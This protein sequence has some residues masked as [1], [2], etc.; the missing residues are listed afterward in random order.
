[1]ILL[2]EKIEVATKVNPWLN[3]VVSI[4]FNLA[5]LYVSHLITLEIW[6]SL[7]GH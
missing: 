4:G 7:T 6:R 3:A 5:A 2:E 1:M